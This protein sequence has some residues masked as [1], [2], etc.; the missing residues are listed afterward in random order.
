MDA[1]K[2]LLLIYG[3]KTLMELTARILGRD[4]YSVRKA[5]GFA[6]AIEQLRSF[7]PDGIVLESDLPDKNG[8]DCCRE[9]RTKSE[10]PIFFISGCSE[11][12]LPAFEAGASDFMKKPEDFELM[13]ARLRR[14][15]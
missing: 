14:I 15:V 10:T 8:L 13:K 11:D 7:T 2:T 6:E 5:I 9:L 3:S 12:E 4:G 1:G